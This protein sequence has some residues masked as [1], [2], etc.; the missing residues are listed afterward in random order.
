MSRTAQAAS[1][2]SCSAIQPASQPASQAQRN[3]ASQPA[4]QQ[5]VLLEYAYSFEYIL[6]YYTH[7]HVGVPA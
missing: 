6:C 4:S 1:W 3:A 5:L 7:V 2:W